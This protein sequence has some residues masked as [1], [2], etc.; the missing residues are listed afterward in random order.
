MRLPFTLIVVTL[1]SI[2]SCTSEDMAKPTRPDTSGMSADAARQWEKAVQVGP[3]NTEAAIAAK[4]RSRTLE[5]ITTGL[6]P[7]DLNR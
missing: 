2:V 6:T 5:P 3:V 1:V 4:E 7:V